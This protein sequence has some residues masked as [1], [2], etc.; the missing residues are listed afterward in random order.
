M[1]GRYDDYTT[2]DLEE[3]YDARDSLEK[4]LDDFFDDDETPHYGDQ[5]YQDIATDLS[6]VED[7]IEERLKKINKKVDI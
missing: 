4:E 5:G 2:W 1:M 3:L 6:N 7:E